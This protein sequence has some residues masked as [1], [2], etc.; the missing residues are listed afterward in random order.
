MLYA[1]QDSLRVEVKIP[2]NLTK[3][4]EGDYVLML[5]NNVG[6]SH[7][8]V[9]DIG[10]FG[11]DFAVSFDTEGAEF[12]DTEMYHHIAWFWPSTPTAGEYSYQLTKGDTVVASGLLMVV[13]GR[14][15][16]EY[17]KEQIYEQF[18]G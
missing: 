11:A 14:N 18:N 1:E 9:A 6:R 15:V 8:E 5:R 13:K 4:P 7:T 3:L 2:R 12:Y 10:D 16:D 17:E